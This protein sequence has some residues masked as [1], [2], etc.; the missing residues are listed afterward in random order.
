MSQKG[1]FP[2]SASGELLAVSLRFD[3]FIAASC[4]ATPSITTSP[5]KEQKDSQE[6]C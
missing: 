3:A 5:Q 6:F 1:V 2:C 4:T